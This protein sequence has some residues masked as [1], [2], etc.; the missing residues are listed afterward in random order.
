MVINWEILNGGTAQITRYYN[1]KLVCE[2]TWGAEDKNAIIRYSVGSSFCGQF[3]FGGRL[4]VQVGIGEEE[5]TTTIPSQVIAGSPDPVL[6]ETTPLNFVEYRWNYLE[7][8]SWERIDYAEPNE[9][10][11]YARNPQGYKSEVFVG[12]NDQQ[13]SVDIR[14]A[15]CQEFET[16]GEQTVSVVPPVSLEI[17]SSIDS[18]AI[19]CVS[20]SP[21]TFSIKNLREGLPLTYRWRLPNGNWNS[22]NSTSK[23][24][25]VRPDGVEAGLLEVEVDM[26][27]NGQAVT[28]RGSQEITVAPYTQTPGIDKSMYFCRH[29]TRSLR[30]LAV[31][32][33]YYYWYSD[34]NIWIDN[35]VATASNP[36]Y[37]TTPSVNI[38]ANLPEGTT[39]A[40]VY[41]YAVNKCG[42]QSP[43]A[44]TQLFVGVP[45]PFDFTIEPFALDHDGRSQITVCYK[46]LFNLQVELFEQSADILDPEILE[47][48]WKVF[49][50]DPTDPNQF[51]LYSGQGER[52][53][54]FIAAD[55]SD[56]PSYIPGT[57]SS[58]QI[59]G[60]RLRT[61]CGWSEYITREVVAKTKIGDRFC[62]APV[63]WEFIPFPNPADGDDEIGIYLN[64]NGETLCM[65]I[66]IDSGDLINIDI[67]DQMGI[68]VQEISTKDKSATIR[69]DKKVY[70][71]LNNL[72]TGKYTIVVDSPRG[73]FSTNMIV[74]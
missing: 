42:Q 30:A 69:E 21:I 29:E 55:V 60:V 57:G 73:K 71:K 3:R 27:V 13:V 4:D 49:T 19:P 32:A 72:P 39:D 1:D 64:D 43:V 53:A 38:T 6:F 25:I 74:K 59:I 48:E 51:Y 34:D 10:L 63:G 66:A 54:Q 23:T 28:V 18:F 52:V 65:C 58:R 50:N 33:E 17:I 62:K 7:Q 15:G 68:R 45:R 61:R 11:S 44:T 22:N 24:L 67:Y 26:V 37:T 47:V 5:V 16:F 12:F 41:M 46:S 9:F 31:G 14:G 20:P 70:F 56:S 36:Y 35:R 2:V 8:W 40:K